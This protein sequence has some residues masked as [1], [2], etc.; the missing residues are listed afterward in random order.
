MMLWL[1]VGSLEVKTKTCGESEGGIK[2]LTYFSEL[3]EMAAL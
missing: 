3:I 2:V 1:V